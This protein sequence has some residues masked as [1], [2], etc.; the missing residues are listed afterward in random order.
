MDSN[1]P[2]LNENKVEIIREHI[3]KTKT[4]VDQSIS[5]LIERGEK[6]EDLV[7]KSEKLNENSKLFNTN[8]RRLKRRMFWRRLKTA[9]IL[10][11]FF[12]FIIMILLFTICGIRFN[13]C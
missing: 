4:N 3:E 1:S 10:F 7:D 2:E 9:F 11:L 6:L 12:F 8:A 13:R 5:L